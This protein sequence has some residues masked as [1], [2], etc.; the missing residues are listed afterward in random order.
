[1]CVHGAVE[2]SPKHSQNRNVHGAALHRR[3]TGQECRWSDTDWLNAL[4]Q[5]L[6]VNI[7]LRACL[8]PSLPSLLSPCASTSPLK[9]FFSLLVPRCISHFLFVGGF[10]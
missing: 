10:L 6:H 3:Q 7:C 5:L 1:M 2:A 8:I 9:A 4:A